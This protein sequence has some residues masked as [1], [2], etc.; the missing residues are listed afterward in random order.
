MRAAA[1]L[2]L[3]GFLAGC[4]GY[5]GGP[6]HA[7]TRNSDPAEQRLTQFSAILPACD[8]AGVLGSLSGD[9]A[10]RE[11]TYWGSNLTL[12]GFDKVRET[13]FRSWGTTFIPRRYCSARAMTS[14]GQLRHV[15]YAIRDRLGVVTATWDLDWCVSGL[16]RHLGHA[17]ACRAAGP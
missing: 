17:P 7:N 15:T 2:L 11:S 12:G 8:D 13:G 6:P 14:D 5:A 9:F 1:F 16:D 3:S 4:A 10:A